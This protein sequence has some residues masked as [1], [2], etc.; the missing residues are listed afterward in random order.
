MKLP[1]YM[2]NHATTAVDTRVAEEMMPCLIQHYGNADSRAH[3]FGR[4]AEKLVEV[5]RVRVAAL[6]GAEAKEIVFTSGATESNN[7]ALKG[8]V[9]KGGHIISAVT[10]HRSI[11]DSLKFLE[12]EGCS[13]TY[14]KVSREGLVDLGA[15]SRAITAKT[16][17]I[18]VMM[19]N[20]EIGVI[21]PIAEIG[22]IAKERGILFHSDATQAVG[23]IPV[24][25]QGL[26]L[27]LVSFSAHKMY[28]PKGIGALWV[29]RRNP[30]VDLVAQI[31]GGGHERGHRS[32]T[33]NVPGIVG[34]GKA[35]EIAGQEM[36]EEARRIARLRDRLMEGLCRELRNISVN[37]SFTKRLSGNL[38]L[39]FDG[40]DAQAALLAVGEEIA[41]STGSACSSARTE[42]SH[43]LKALGLNDE[44]ALSAIRFGIGRFNTEEEIDYTVTKI[45]QTVG[46]LRE[47]SPT[48]QIRPQL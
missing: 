36:T 21:Q 6:I 23:R 10:E 48:K 17:L 16:S 28:G 35:C 22:Q 11:L 40:V 41:L 33:L 1:I 32:G 27:D 24:D 5:A 30:H 4:E 8:V 12:G 29:R 37:G 18:S 19:A 14:L 13:V 26:H 47:F 44:T 25:V 46:R 20:N 42:P 7:L 31:H 9:R 39:S 3:V 38:N 34:F 2:D 45:A 43:V 15:L